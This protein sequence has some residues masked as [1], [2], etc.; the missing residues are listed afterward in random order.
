MQNGRVTSEAIGMNKASELA[1]QNGAQIYWDVNVCQNVASYEKDGISCQIWME[2]NQSI[3]EK[4]KLIPKYALGGIA[5][6][7]LGFEDSSIWS[8]ILDNLQG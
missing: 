7:S 5:S 4:T 2:D 3:A 8:T 1:A 6:W